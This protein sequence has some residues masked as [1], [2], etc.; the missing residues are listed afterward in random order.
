VCAEDGRALIA[1]SPL[2]IPLTKIGEVISDR[3]ATIT[4]EGVTGELQR[5]GWSH[6]FG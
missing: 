2:T 1:H 4:T 6:N 3:D 5:G